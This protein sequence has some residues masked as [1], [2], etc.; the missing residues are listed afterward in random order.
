[1]RHESSHRSCRHHFNSE[2]DSRTVCAELRQ[3]NIF[4]NVLGHFTFQ[5]G[6]N[7]QLQEHMGS[8]PEVR[9]TEAEP[10]PRVVQY[11]QKE[12]GITETAAEL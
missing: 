11:R 6:R 1:M 8:S 2:P 7:T 9:E 10:A 5:S 3:D 4:P 12:D